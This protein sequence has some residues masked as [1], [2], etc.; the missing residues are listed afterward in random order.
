MGGI[1]LGAPSVAVYTGQFYIVADGSDGTTL[2]QNYWGA[3]G[4]SGWQGIVAGADQPFAIA[5]GG[6]LHIL[7]RTSTTSGLAHAWCG[8]CDGTDWGFEGQPVVDTGHSFTVT[9]WV[10]LTGSSITRPETAAGVDGV[11]VSGFLLGEDNGA[12][13]PRW[14]F[15]MHKADANNDAGD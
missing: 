3:N 1:I 4:W 15:E 6:Q 12:G 11:H 7:A 9:A 14:R 10:R 8:V 13:P 2:F 5:D